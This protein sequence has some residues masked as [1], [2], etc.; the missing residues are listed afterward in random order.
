MENSINLIEFVEQSSSVEKWREKKTFKFSCTFLHK[1][2][3]Y[4]GEEESKNV[5]RIGKSDHV[6]NFSS[7]QANQSTSQQQNKREWITKWNKFVEIAK[8]KKKKQ[9]KEL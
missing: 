7:A 3:E 1:I 9:I 4:R 5:G 8:E 2:E 6:R